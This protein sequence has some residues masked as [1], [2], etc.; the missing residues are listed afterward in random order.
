MYRKKFLATVREFCECSQQSRFVKI[1][2][3][4]SWGFQ[5]NVLVISTKQ[6]LQNFYVKSTYMIFVQQQSIVRTG[7]SDMRQHVFPC[8]KSSTKT[9]SVGR[10]S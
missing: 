4:I 8:R 3:L 7:K 10:Y 9:K 2:L 5:R 6:C 1:L